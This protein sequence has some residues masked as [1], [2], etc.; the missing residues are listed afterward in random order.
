[1]SKRSQ[2]Q[3][4]LFVLF[5]CIAAIVLLNLVG[6]FLF[7]RFDLTTEKRYTLSSA[8]IE[9]L[10]NLDDIAYFKIYL[11]GDNLDANYK[12][13][14]NETKEMLDEFRVY[15]GDNI[16]YEFVNPSQSPDKNQR[17]EVYT[18]LSK[19]GLLPTTLSETGKDEVTQKIL[20]P[21]AIITYKERETPV[22]LLKPQLGFSQ[23]V[24]INSS[25]Q[26][27]E[28]EISNAIRKLAV[29]KKPKVAILAGHGELSEIWLRDFIK[30]LDEYYEVSLNKINENIKGL[31][32]KDALIIAQPDSAFSEKDK[33]VI[34]QFIMHGGKV[35]WMIDPIYANM[36][37]L[38]DK[39]VMFGLP[40]ELN[41]EDQLFKYGVRLNTNLIMDVQAAPIPMITGNV[42]NQSQRSLLP[43]Y[44]FPLAFPISKHPIVNNLNAVKFD[45]ASTID[46]VNSK[47]VQKTILLT[48]SKYSRALNAPVRIS[49]E[50]LRKE[51]EEKLYN[52]SFMPISVLLEGNFESLYKNRI[53]PAIANDSVIDFKSSSL[54]TKM[55]V[56]ADG[57][58]CKNQVQKNTQNVYP[59][60]Y[61]RFSGQTFGNKNF[62]LN[63][64][65]YL[66]DN[67]GL[68]SVRS[69]E[70]K[71]RL[72]DKKKAEENKSAIKIASTTIPILIIILIGIA[73]YILRKNKYS[74]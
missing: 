5:I 62:L 22:Q 36:D 66:L 74:K 51:P 37:S 30:S 70:L 7:K 9:L 53:P 56:I 32:N 57:D 48:S 21:G 35:L 71:L 44:F 25:I 16:Q 10:K 54:T 61:D 27:L 45:F 26:G 19:K 63:C 52:K 34:D 2:K 13:L 12:R 55:I 28:Y 59:L 8:T 49:L 64:M 14:R 43:W 6:S 41:L 60:G 39:P 24:N 20:F 18:L 4:S 42:G 46:T 1:M 73:Q 50:V 31:E 23:E 69:R 40:I 3:Q 17:F 33:F 68:I 58:V 65:N 67:S 29:I 38:R 15:A 47:N 11:E 72:L